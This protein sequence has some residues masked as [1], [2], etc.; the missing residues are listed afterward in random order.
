MSS[1]LLLLLA[2]CIFF[3]I[4][5]LLYR[6]LFL[7][8]VLFVSQTFTLESFAI[9]IHHHL[10][11]G[12]GHRFFK[13]QRPEEVHAKTSSLRGIKQFLELQ[14]RHMKSEKTIDFHNF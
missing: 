13:F 14:I 2:Q 7:I 12:C 5:L 4:N 11:Q 3:E 6:N 10:N 1:I 9:E 8:A